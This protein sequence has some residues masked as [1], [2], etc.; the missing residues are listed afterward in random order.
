MK[1]IIIPKL[2]YQNQGVKLVITNQKLKIQ[3]VSM[4]Y[5]EN[6]VINVY[7]VWSKVNTF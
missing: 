6:L 1:K 3:I 4:C 7:P 2:K 5:P